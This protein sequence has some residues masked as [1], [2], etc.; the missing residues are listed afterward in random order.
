MSV[1]KGV[2]QNQ[3]MENDSLACCEEEVHSLSQIHDIYTNY[4]N[5]PFNWWKNEYCQ[6]YSQLGTTA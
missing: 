3:K 1:K 4:F 6:L 5:F 2:T